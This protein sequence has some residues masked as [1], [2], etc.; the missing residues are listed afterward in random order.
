MIPMDIEAGKEDVDSGVELSRPSI[1]GQV[2]QLKMEMPF[3]PRERVEE[4]FNGIIVQEQARL[5]LSYEDCFA[6]AGSDK[7]MELL[8]EAISEDLRDSCEEFVSILTK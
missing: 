4:I 6:T 2:A 1:L 8:G 3:S 5:L 7:D